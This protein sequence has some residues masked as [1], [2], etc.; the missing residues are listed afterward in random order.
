MFEGIQYSSSNPLSTQ[1]VHVHH[2]DS[3]ICYEHIMHMVKVIVYNI[4][5]LCP[6]LWSSMHSFFCYWCCSWR[7]GCSCSGGSCRNRSDSRSK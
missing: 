1:D 7:R 6:V 4:A 5:C 2:A 3:E